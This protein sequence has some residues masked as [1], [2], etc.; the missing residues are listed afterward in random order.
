MANT[1][2]EKILEVA[3]RI[4]SLRQ[5]MGISCE[6]MAAKTGF[7]AEE[8]CIIISSSSDCDQREFGSIRDI[9]SASNRTP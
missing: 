7:S 8:S 4:R 3:Q 1:T 6:T 2:E 9:S 5:D